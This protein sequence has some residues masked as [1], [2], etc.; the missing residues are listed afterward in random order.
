MAIST[1][2]LAGET[3]KIPGKEPQ[4]PPVANHHNDYAKQLLAEIRGDHVQQC[5]GGRLFRR[6][7][8]Y[9]NP[10]ISFAVENMNSLEIDRANG[11]YA[12]FSSMDA[13]VF[14]FSCGDPENV[15]VDAQKQWTVFSFRIGAN[16]YS[17]SELYASGQS[18]ST[19]AEK[20]MFQLVNLLAHY[21]QKLTKLQKDYQSLDC[22]SLETI[23]INE[24]GQLRILPLRAY[25]NH[26]PIE[27][28][29]EEGG[30]DIKNDLFSAAFVAAQVESGGPYG[31]KALSEPK[32]QIVRNC[33]KI[34][35]EWR[36]DF[37][38][39]M[40]E[41][42]CD[43]QITSVKKDETGNPVAR[44][45]IHPRRPSFFSGFVNRILGEEKETREQTR[46][47]WDYGDHGPNHDGAPSMY[48]G[49]V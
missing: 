17:L 16:E 1:K 35:K 10:L 44:P 22:L 45:E 49:K 12:A 41:L 15:V 38:S 43:G 2:L 30:N 37:Q 25:N 42:K 28:S 23:F 20:T 18:Y 27:I 32:A 6:L 5:F 47:T 26:Y 34:V 46:G 7:D 31:K 4:S 48:S 33:L 3:T 24:D 19:P 36:P 9:G 29:R 39:V 11:A 21:K 13:G 14:L 40:N 8:R